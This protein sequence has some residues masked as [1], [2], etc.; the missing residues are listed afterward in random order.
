MNKKELENLIEKYL[1]GDCSPAEL[2][3]LMAIFRD[4]P[5]NDLK[6]LI[7]QNWNSTSDDIPAE[8][9]RE[10]FQKTDETLQSIWNYEDKKPLWQMGGKSKLFM[11]AAA[12]I[13][14][15]S[16][17]FS[18]WKFL[19]TPL[20]TTVEQTY[21]SSVPN[22]LILPNG[23]TIEL[24]DTEEDKIVWEDEWT[25]IVQL[26]A[27][28]L[29]L[30]DKVKSSSIR[31]DLR[32][33]VAKGKKVK[34]HFSDGSTA[35]INSDSYLKFPAQFGSSSRMVFLSGE[36][37]F[38]I[39]H[40]SQHPF[41]VEGVEQ[42]IKVYGTRFNVRSYETEGVNRTTLYEGKLSVRKKYNTKLHAE[43]M[44]NPGD[45]YELFKDTEVVRLSTLPE[46]QLMVSWTSDRTYYNRT[47]L[48]EIFMDLSHQYVI[49]VDW[50][51][52]PHLHY[53]GY[54][55]QGQD[56]DRIL[57]ILSRTS[58]INIKRKGNEIVFLT[59]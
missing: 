36:A 13:L 6:G 16:I 50:E 20:P 46:D 21:L 54:L 10:I 33:H 29:H 8:E 45:H 5:S 35:W 56:L 52:I 7:Q 22:T 12:I 31:K 38:E 1:N 39:K 9:L 37:Y 51:Q 59:N 2:E 44:L 30:V 28:E 4:Q 41:Y 47:S 40:A 57:F 42:L 25:K 23:K 55:P 14:V 24:G 27:D 53:Q 34:I 32:L 18:V 48:R 19:S 26:A 43:Q 49:E 58:N 3:E 17:G 11:A 15:V